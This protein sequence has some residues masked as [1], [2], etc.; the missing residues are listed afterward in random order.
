MNL[1]FIRNMKILTDR[2][3]NF[4]HRE[5][6]HDQSIHNFEKTDLSKI[7]NQNINIKKTNEQTLINR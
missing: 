1:H 4:L 5:I 3:N 2:L 7:R 6:P